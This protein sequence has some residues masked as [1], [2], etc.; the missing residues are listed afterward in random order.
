MGSNTQNEMEIRVN[1]ASRMPKP[2]LRWWRY[3]PKSQQKTMPKNSSRLKL[4]F[5]ARRHSK[6]SLFAPLGISNFNILTMATWSD[7]VGRER[8]AKHD[9]ET[10][11]FS[12]TEGKAGNVLRYV[13]QIYYIR[14]EARRVGIIEAPKVAGKLN[15][16]DNKLPFQSGSPDAYPEVRNLIFMTG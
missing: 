14:E 12:R 8:V 5:W 1:E 10:H 3:S 9:F 16:F 13:C 2:V 11:E 4:S 7:G 15:L 6:K